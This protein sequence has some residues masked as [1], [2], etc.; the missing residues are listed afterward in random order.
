MS[1]VEFTAIFA[2]ASFF[3]L[4]VLS[5]TGGR[6]A[7]FLRDRDMFGLFP[8]WNFFA[9]DPGRVDFHLLFRDEL[10]SGV[11]TS[12]RE[13]PL[14]S[15]RRWHDWLWNP[16]RRL[17]K[18]VF[19]AFAGLSQVVALR[20]DVRLSIP[21]LVLLNCVSAYPRIY[22]FERTQFL[23]MMSTPAEPDEEPVEV[24][25]SDRHNR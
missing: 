5:Q 25:L 20:A 23:V 14:T 21:Y 24:V 22:A 6:A 10:P 8:G 2:L 19:D 15:G 18:V 3:A 12:W 4:T 13:I 11:V 7:L 9:P 17:K 16:E 1:P